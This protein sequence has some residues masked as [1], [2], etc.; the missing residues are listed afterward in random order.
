M[1]CHPDFLVLFIEHRQSRFSIILKRLRI[2]RMVDVHWLNFKSPAVL[3]R[4]KIVSLSFVA[5]KPGIDFS[6]LAMKV[7]DGIF[8]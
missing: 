8:F 6:S 2:F 4:N 1:C 5:L 3:A 7:L